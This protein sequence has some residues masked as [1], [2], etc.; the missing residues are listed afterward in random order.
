MTKVAFRMAEPS[1]VVFIYQSLSAMVV[2]ENIAERF[3]LT[4]NSLAEALF[5]G[6]PIAEVLLA[7]ADGQIAGLVLFSTTNRNFDL[8]ASPGIYLH[9][10]YVTQPYR[11]Q[12]VGTQLMQKMKEIAQARKY[13]RV[14]WLVLKDNQQ[15]CDFYQ[16][17]AEA[18]EVNSINYWR[19]KI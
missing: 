12:G 18:Q 17:V 19:I 15:G 5:S 1:D 6:M 3:T 4:E 10:V 11:R 13:S 14:D 16:K 9:D 2:E 7:I 8:F